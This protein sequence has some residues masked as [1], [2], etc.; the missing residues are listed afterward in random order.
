MKLQKLLGAA[1][2]GAGFAVIPATSAHAI[3]GP[4]TLTVIAYF[5]DSGKQTVVG[6]QWSGCGRPS[7]QWGDTT[8]YLSLYFPAC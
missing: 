4:N 1:V 2:L 5:S 6:Q 3:G 8:P 7:G